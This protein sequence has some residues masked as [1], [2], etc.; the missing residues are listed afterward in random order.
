MTQRLIEQ[1]CEEI[2]TRKLVL[3][4]SHA[5]LKPSA[6]NFIKDSQRRLILKPVL[7][8]LL[9]ALGSQ[10]KLEVH[11]SQIL[12]KLPE[13]SPRQPGYAA[14]NLLNLLCQLKAN[15]SEGGCQLKYEL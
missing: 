4:N 12:T 7:D 8:R 2:T 5:L 13:E 11:L 14:S 3:F 6:N 15:F 1:V 10:N 9:F